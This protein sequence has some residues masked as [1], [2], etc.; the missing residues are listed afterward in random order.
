MLLFLPSALRLV[1]L[2][3]PSAGPDP[4]EAH[5][6][7]FAV[8]DNDSTISV[9]GSADKPLLQLRTKHPVDLF[10][11]CVGGGLTVLAGGKVSLYS[12][13]E[14]KPAGSW[15]AGSAKILAP[16]ARLLVFSSPVDAEPATGPTDE[17]QPEEGIEEVALAAARTT[18]EWVAPMGAKAPGQ[19]CLTIVDMQTG[20]TGNEESILYVFL[21]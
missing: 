3:A 13:P 18:M 16:A 9:R 17:E 11:A 20:E 6:P 2:W 5:R 14:L 7:C 8:L 21:F 10:A 12:G 19:G 4:L 15:P 1:P